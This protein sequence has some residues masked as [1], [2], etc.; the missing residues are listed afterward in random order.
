LELKVVLEEL[1]ARY[2]ALRLVEGEAFT[3]HPNMSFRGPEHLLVSVHGE[4]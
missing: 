2:P 1:A 3:Y 4:P